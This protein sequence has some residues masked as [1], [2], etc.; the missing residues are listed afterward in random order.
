MLWKTPIANSARQRA[1]PSR[2]SRFRLCGRIHRGCEMRNCRVE[3]SPTGS[4]ALLKLSLGIQHCRVQGRVELNLCASR[5]VP[6]RGGS[7]EH[8]TLEHAHFEFVAFDH[9]NLPEAACRRIRQS[10]VQH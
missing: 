6:N 1:E 3:G 2:N 10:L 5:I 4:H 8:V 9:E 7:L